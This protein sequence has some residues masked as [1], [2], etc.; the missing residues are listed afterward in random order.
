MKTT[1]LL[2]LIFLFSGRLLD[3]SPTDILTESN[4]NFLKEEQSEVDDEIPH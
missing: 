1:F 3:Q 2:F 4:D